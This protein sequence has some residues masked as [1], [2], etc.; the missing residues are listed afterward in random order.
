M[1]LSSLSKEEINF[2]IESFLCVTF[3]FAST[4]KFLNVIL[5]SHQENFHFRLNNT[6]DTF[7]EPLMPYFRL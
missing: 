1:L 6:G 7:V 3:H 5:I 2:M 4:L